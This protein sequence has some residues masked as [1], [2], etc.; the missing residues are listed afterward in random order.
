MSWLPTLAVAGLLTFLI[1]LSFIAL[2]G[3]VETPPLLA[4]AL[5]LVP[6]AVLS[7]IILPELLLRRGAVDL[8]L[9]NVRLLAGLLATGVA[10][11]TRNVLATIGAG[12][13]ALWL[14]QYLVAR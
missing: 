14:L 8:S 13:A 3:R 6:P 9:G 7:A 11:W 10:I 1:R 2:L 4:R 5:R 12:M